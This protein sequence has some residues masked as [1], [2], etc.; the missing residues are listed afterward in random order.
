MKTLAAAHPREDR[1]HR[2]VVMSLAAFFCFTLI[3]T[4]AK[5]LVASLPALQVV[6]IRYAG[7]FA[8][9]L[10]VFL[11]TEGTNLFRSHTPLLQVGR[12]ALL[13]S[14]TTFNF[15]A[16]ETLPLTITTAIFF[17]APVLVCL[18]SIPM[19]GEKVGIRRLLAVLTGFVGVLI[20]VQPGGTA[21]H[22]AMFYSLAALL[23]A[24]LYF[25]LTRLVAGR[26]NNPTG[27]IYTS[28]LPTLCLLPFVL[29]GW[30]WP[31]G[32]EWGPT[33]LIGIFGGLGH[34]LLTVAHRYGEAS[35]LAPI[36]YVQILYATAISWLVFAHVPGEE[37]IL[38]T[39]VIVASGLYIWLR[40]RK[41]HEPI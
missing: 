17:A 4:F 27:Q 21:F 9:S 15:I 29:S 39:A 6:F 26:D 36:V 7:H 12:A 41:K 22:P 25:I 2:A 10:A 38:G 13:L 1:L 5:L 23:S 30:V 35:V 8:F 11:P 31:T 33:L 40:E 18:L 32:W 16:L 20:I 19:L 24:S 3:D 34:S 28:G 37:T 14:G